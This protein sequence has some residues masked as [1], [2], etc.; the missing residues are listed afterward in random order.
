MAII[1]D[2]KALPSLAVDITSPSYL[3]LYLSKYSKY[4]SSF[5]RRR[6]ESFMY[7]NTRILEIN[8]QIQQKQFGEIQ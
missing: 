5:R 2:V 7:F 3:M 4:T 6:Y 8:R 1:R